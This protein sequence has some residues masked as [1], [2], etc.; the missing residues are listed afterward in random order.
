M[1]SA[2]TVQVRKSKIADHLWN[3][4]GF[5]EQ[6]PSEDISSPTV[7]K[8]QHGEEKTDI[9]GDVATTTTSTTPLLKSVVKERKVGLFD[10]SF[11]GGGK[12]DDKQ[13]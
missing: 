8:H 3:W 1:P 5:C 11:G 2:T 6:S 13:D 12:Q 7:G 4:T 9:N 10:K